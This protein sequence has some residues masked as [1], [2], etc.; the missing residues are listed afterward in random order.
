MVACVSTAIH[1]K[2][3]TLRSIK[4]NMK[5]SIKNLCYLL[6]LLLTGCTAAHKQSLKPPHLLP[7]TGG[8]VS[9]YLNVD[10]PIQQDH[11][12]FDQLELCSDSVW[13]PLTSIENIR[14]TNVIKQKLIAVDSV[15]TGIISKI[16]FRVEITDQEGNKEVSQHSELSLTEPFELHN[17]SSQCL[18][19][20]GQLHLARP[21]TPIQTWLTVSPQKAPL[22]D[23]LLYIL[24]PEIHSIYLARMDQYRIIAAY[25]VEGEVVEMKLDATK[26][27]LYLLDKKNLLIQRFDTT[28]QL[29]TDRI[30]LPLTESPQGLEISANG[31]TLFVTDPNNRQ[32]LS[33]NT[34]NG[35]LTNSVSVGYDPTRPHFFTHNGTDYL[36]ILSKAD[37]QLIVLDTE[38]LA[39][40]YSVAAGQSP[41][42]II[43]ADQSLF[44]ADEFNRQILLFEPETGQIRAKI[45][46]NGS[47][48]RFA[49]DPLNQNILITLQDQHAVTFL[50]FGQQMTVR[51]A[52]CGA[53]PGDLKISNNRQLLFVANQT[54]NQII[55]LDLLSQQQISTLT[56]GATPTVLVIQ[57]P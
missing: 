53:S 55:V 7:S 2:I 49:V 11:I 24:C 45:S 35:T 33:I 51:K 8:I 4:V 57:E 17:G 1:Q 54:E 22:T 34:Y 15:P 32:V 42:D 13:Y 28:T 26:R 48:Q 3:N 6:L 52:P 43:Y 30:P 19:L 47:P 21:N 36:A 5:H 38:D 44:V 10:Q 25:A 12:T 20:H 18:F 14:S 56:I 31:D 40:L 9:I 50:P 23:E 29:M 41:Q 27:L 37:Q 16:R 46:T 39:P